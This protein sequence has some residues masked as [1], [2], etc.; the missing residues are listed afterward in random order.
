MSSEW[1]KKVKTYHSQHPELSYK[2]CLIT[3][4]KKN[5]KKQN[6]GSFERDRTW[7]VKPYEQK[8]QAPLE[9]NVDVLK[10]YIKKKKQK[11]GN[12]ALLAL[13][14]NSGQISEALD[15]I[16]GNITEAVDKQQER[17]FEKNKITGWYDMRKR[18]KNERFIEEKT[19]D[20]FN[21]Y[22]RLRDKGKF[23]MWSDNQIWEYAQQQL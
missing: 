4:G 1:I 12:P 15:S 7:E 13:A 23:P 3:L 22:K 14:Q 18:F 2:E 16:I 17:G 9:R 10:E 8:L 20:L 21:K 19:I 11:G 5:K 6:G